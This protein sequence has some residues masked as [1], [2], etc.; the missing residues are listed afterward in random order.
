MTPNQRVLIEKSLA[1]IGYIAIL[2]L[3]A[4]V[5]WV[6]YGAATTTRFD[7]ASGAYM[8]GAATR[9]LLHIDYAGT[10]F[11]SAAGVSTV[12]FWLRSFLRAGSVNKVDSE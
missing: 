1:T 2:A 8:L 11:Y 9:A 5:L 7:G 12:A 10:A 3:V 6:I 4:I